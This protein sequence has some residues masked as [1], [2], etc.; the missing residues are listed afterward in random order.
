MAVNDPVTIST[1]FKITV[2]DSDKAIGAGVS[3][4]FSDG[5]INMTLKNADSGVIR[6]LDYT[7][8]E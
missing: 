5:N 1:G 4:T 8:T 6:T 7:K 3:A 2:S